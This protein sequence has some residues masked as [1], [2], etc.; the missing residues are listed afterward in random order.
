MKSFDEVLAD[1]L[2]S[3]LTKTPFTNVNVG[4]A[5]R[6]LL[7]SIASGV[8]GLYQLVRTVSGALFIQ[9]ATGTWLDLKAREVGVRR[10]VA[11]QAQIRLTFGRATPATQDTLIPAGTIVRS[12]KDST[13]SST[14][15]LT[16]NDVTLQTG[17]SATYV[18]A[19]AETAGVAGNVGPA[20]VTLI[21][22]PISG[23]ET[24]T[25]VDREGIP[26][27]AQEG[28]DAESDRAF[29][30]RA[31]GKWDTLGVGGTRGAYHAWALSVA[32]VQAAM[33]LDD[34]PYGPGTVGV[35]VLG[36]NGAPTP[37]LLAAVKDFIRPRQP[38]TAHLV[39][40][41]AIITPVALSLTVWRYATADQATVDADV[42]LALQ[43]Y[44]DGLQLGEGL[45]RARLVA[46]VMGVDGVYNVTVD[47]PTADVPATPAEYLD[48]DAAV[49][50]L[51]HRVKGRGYQDRDQV[52]AGEPVT[53]IDPIDKSEWDL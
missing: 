17:Q 6:G 5:L 30:E 50:T 12:K 45:I 44:S 11:K 8:A 1:L 32:G 10:L 38:L 43:D 41:G 39:V 20:T 51:V 27:L 4:A 13:G 47:S 15:F 34:A 23:I 40:S 49:A 18:T 35:V 21:V 53:I 3:V 28:A 22:T 2:A 19:T 31:I 9:T 29:R 7:E 14:R 26:Y 16:D 48:V 37:A 52:P 25:N 46:A 24:V 42:R 33:V 36:T